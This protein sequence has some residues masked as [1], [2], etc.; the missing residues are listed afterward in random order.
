[1]EDRKKADSH[2]ETIE[3]HYGKDY[4]VQSAKYYIESYMK[5]HGYKAL[6]DLIKR[7]R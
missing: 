2:K 6:I 3:R 5:K 4:G 1:M 7:N